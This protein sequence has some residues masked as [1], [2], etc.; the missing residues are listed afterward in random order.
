MKEGVPQ[1][2]NPVTEVWEPMKIDEITDKMVEAGVD[3]LW[4]Y[5]PGWNDRET[6]EA[7]YRAMRAARTR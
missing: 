7:V 1:R 5:D 2:F 4:H 3:V 6:A